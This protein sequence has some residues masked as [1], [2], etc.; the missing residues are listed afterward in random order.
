MYPLQVLLNQAKS[1]VVLH[2]GSEASQLFSDEYN[3]DTEA[4]DNGR[5][6]NDK[7][8]WFHVLEYTSHS[9]TEQ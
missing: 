6:E 3:N 9:I 1:R 7:E 8:S 2:A 4:K 5:Q